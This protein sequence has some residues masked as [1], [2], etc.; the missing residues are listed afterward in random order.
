MLGTNL[1]CNG[2]CQQCLGT[3][4]AVIGKKVF[5]HAVVIRN[6]NFVPAIKQH[7]TGK[8]LKLWPVAER[9]T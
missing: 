7:M 8:K 2:I 6:H 1:R 4:L 3:Y 9:K 5:I